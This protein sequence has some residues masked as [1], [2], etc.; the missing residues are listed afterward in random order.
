[1]VVVDQSGKIEDSARGFSPDHAALR[2]F[3]QPD[4]LSFGPQSMASDSCARSLIIV[5]LKVKPEL[6]SVT[7]KESQAQR[8]VGGDQ[9]AIVDDLGDSI[10]RDPDR[11]RELILRQLVLRRNSP[12]SI[13]PGVLAN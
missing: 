2:Y 1:M 10:R 9:S 3:R 7:E 6:G 12:F 4:G 13:L 5:S 11:L 8:C